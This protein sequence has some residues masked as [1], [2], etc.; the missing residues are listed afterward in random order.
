MHH[1][2]PAESLYGFLAAFSSSSVFMFEWEIILAAG[3]IFLCFDV[4]C[5]MKKLDVKNWGKQPRNDHNKVFFELN[6]AFI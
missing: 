2:F 6:K 3:H 1:V 5:V 4:L